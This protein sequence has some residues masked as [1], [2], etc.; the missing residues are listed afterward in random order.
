VKRRRSLKRGWE[1]TWKAAVAVG[2]L[3][4]AFLFLQT[5]LT[6][7]K[8]TAEKGNADPFENS[9]TTN[10]EAYALYLQ[11]REC[12]KNRYQ[13]AFHRAIARFE[14][15][16]SKDPNFARAW[17]ELAMVHSRLD[18]HEATAP[19]IC[20][21]KSRE[22]A[23]KALGL[24]NSLVEAHVVLGTYQ[25]FF[26]WDW[27]G[28]ERELKKALT[29]APRNSEARWQYA[30]L[31]SM[32]GRH[33]EAIREARRALEL[34]P[35]VVGLNTLIGVLLFRAGHKEEAANQ[36]KKALAVNPNDATAMFQL[37]KVLWTLGRHDDA[38]SEFER[39]NVLY[40]SSAGIEGKAHEAYRIAG[41]G[42]AGLAAYCRVCLEHL[43]ARERSRK[44]DE[45]IPSMDWVWYYTIMG[46]LDNAF[47]WWDRGCEERQPLAVWAV[48]DPF[49][50]RLWSD[51][52]F[53]E[54]LRRMG[55]D[56][57]FAEP[58]HSAQGA[59]KAR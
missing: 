9:G 37:A 28:A 22:A 5:E 1:R 57:Y 26:E 19:R 49:F 23:L 41:G 34:N 2:L 38:M 44:S 20:R 16:V 50:E 11:G 29:L 59:E 54:M 47:K 40:S 7:L 58:I 4:I 13:D 3:G 8:T 31:L 30:D 39:F 18:V 27:A 43:E 46:D 48:V 42:Q 51:P 52:R 25:M 45:W 24:D 53:D 33:D 35:D 14:E 6:R 21:P 32:T 36:I 10:R 15:A 17:A 12:L 56:R 55:L